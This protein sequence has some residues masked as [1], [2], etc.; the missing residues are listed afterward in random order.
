MNCGDESAS[1]YAGCDCHEQH[2]EMQLFMVTA[3]RDG[4]RKAAQTYY[5]QI[6]VLRAELAKTQGAMAADDERLRRAG[7][8]V[9]IEMGCDTPDWMAESILA[10][11]DELARLTS[12][13]DEAIKKEKSISRELTKYIAQDTNDGKQVRNLWDK[14]ERERDALQAKLDALAAA[15]AAEAPVGRSR[16]ALL[17]RVAELE[18]MVRVDNAVCLCGCGEHENLGEDGESCGDDA[19][20][21]L[22]V[23]PSVLSYVNGLRAAL[24]APAAEGKGTVK[25]SLS[26]GETARTH[27]SAPAAEAGRT[28]WTGCDCKEPCGLKQDELSEWD[29]CPNCD[30]APKCHAAP[31]QRGSE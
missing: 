23:A 26:V 22:R 6:A 17:R 20:F 31:K 1:H 16:S 5:D 25:E 24:I 7:E 14:I 2:H 21:C 30:H 18:E 11:R 9:G 13:R 4:A 12:E 10:L 8:R 28:G 15:P 29:Y 3:E 19:H 27:A